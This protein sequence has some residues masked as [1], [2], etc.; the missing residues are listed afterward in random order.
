MNFKTL[1]NMGWKFEIISF[2]CRREYYDLHPASSCGNGLLLHLF[3]FSERGE[4]TV[5]GKKSSR[6]Q[7]SE[8]DD[9][10]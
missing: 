10:T 7:C 8:F 2:V 6:T 9:N 3:D 4:I 5:N 1:L